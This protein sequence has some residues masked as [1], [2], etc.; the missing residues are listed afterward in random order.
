MTEEL[1]Q[2]CM[3]AI[4]VVAPDVHTMRAGKAAL[5]ILEHCGYSRTA[6]VLRIPP[7]IWFVELGYWIVARN[8]RFFTRFLFRKESKE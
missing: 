3:R 8:R 2:R 6:R 7:L 1:H 4:H 5:F